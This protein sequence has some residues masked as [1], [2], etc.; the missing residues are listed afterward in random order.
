ML[1]TDSA[2]LAER[3]REL[4]DVEY[5]SV[6]TEFIREHT[7]HPQLC[8]VQ[9]CGPDRK[10]FAIDALADH[11][12]LSP[13]LDLLGDRGVM[14][15]FHSGRQD[16]EIFHG[17]TGAVPAP[18]FDTQVAAMV[19]GF[20]DS[21]GF[22]TLASRLAGAPVDKSS[23]F[24]DWTLRPLSQRQLDYA[25][26]DVTH[27][28]TVYEKL[29]EQLDGSERTEWLSEEMATLGDRATYE[30]DPRES[31]RRISH[32]RARPRALA[33]LRELAAWRE[34]AA[35]RLD[36][37]RSRVVRDEALLEIASSVPDSPRQLAR[38]RGLSRRVAE[39]RMGGEILAAVRRGMAVPDDEC[40]RLPSSPRRPE[41]AAEMVSLLQALLK[42]RSEEHDVA[43]RLIA[44]RPDLE[45]LVA[46]S[47]ADIPALSGWRRRLFGDD[48]LALKHGRIA[49]TG[50][51]GG[52]KVISGNA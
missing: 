41:N 2:A 18:M 11:V 28:C 29:R 44:T 40:P 45:R 26:A 31:W 47:D 19:C 21:V 25:L 43:P 48:A 38:T 6:D 32:R 35:A 20:G 33:V 14:K 5:V 1:I 42:V 50:G 27:L 34:E 12:D 24:S 10:P 36:V 3:C 9:L 39:G 4:A 23:Q 8:L 37:P 30:I 22:G 13:V 49:L 46:D 52:V 15:V 16:I 17:L 7:Y 51:P